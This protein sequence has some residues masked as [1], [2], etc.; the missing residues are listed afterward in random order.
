[1]AEI[2][3]LGLSHYPPLNG[4]DD[5]MAGALNAVLRDPGLPEQYRTPDGW[6]EPMRR[7]WGTDEGLSA[8]REHRRKLVDEFR[9]LRRKLDDFKPD[10]VLVWGDDQYENFRED[11]IPPYCTLAYDDMDVQPFGAK[12]M[13]LFGDNVWGEPLDKAFRIPGARAQAKALTTGLI[14]QGIDMAYAYKPL[15]LDGLPHPFIN[16]CLFLDYD[17]KGWT[18]PLVS[19]QVNCYGRLVVSQHG[20]IP[21]LRKMPSAEQLDP[22]APAPWRCFELGRAVARVVQRMP[23]R[24]ALVAS[25]S[26]S[27]AFLTAK[28][29]FIYPDSEADALLFRALQQHDWETW[30]SYPLSAIEASGQQEVLNWHCLIGA[31]AELGHKAD[32]T[33]L[34]QTWIFN[35]SKAFASFSAGT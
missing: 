32:Y 24:V 27:H 30:R 33:S 18:Y 26:W 12:Q 23:G 17:R 10:W 20:G 16:T 9:L 1:M 6:P 29:N 14:E 21:N 25:S 11:I 13:A 19:M 4:Q 7:E 28:N 2:L 8:A 5:R 34:V 3:G 35:S 31:M 22:P 15:H